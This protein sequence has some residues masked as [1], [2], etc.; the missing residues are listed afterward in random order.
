MIRLALAL[1]LAV[2]AAQAVDHLGRRRGLDPPGFRNPHRR[3]L[4][5]VLLAFLFLIGIF[6]PA[7]HFDQLPE[8]DL[9]SLR[10]SSIFFFQT[11]LLAALAL[12]LALGY[13]AV[14][15]ESPAESAS[16]TT[17]DGGQR[18][19]HLLSVFGLRCRDPFTELA[20][21][22]AAG[23]VAWGAVLT[24]VTALAL[25]LKGVG[26]DRIIGGQPPEMIVWMAGLPVAL[27]LAISLSAGI[28]EELFFRGFLQLRAGIGLSTFLFVCGHLG[29]GQPFMLVGLTLLSLFY[30][31][32]V[33]WRGNIWAAVA[34]HAIFD[35]VQLLVVIPAALEALEGGHGPAFLTALGIC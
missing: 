17:A 16:P 23:L 21:G 32:L 13:L 29:Y 28:V 3:V 25:F 24:L 19:R 20:L 9:E 14:E 10:P 8:I 27:K 7:V 30:A 22:S 1:I 33:R 6:I 35:A 18:R 34:A 2:T 26:G 5:S 4:A 31:F 11:L 15:G 12:W